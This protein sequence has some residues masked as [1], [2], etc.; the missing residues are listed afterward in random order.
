MTEQATMAHIEPSEMTKTSQQIDIMIAKKNQAL[1]CM[2]NDNMII[3]DCDQQLAR[4]TNKVREL[5]GQVTFDTK[6][7]RTNSAHPTSTTRSILTKEQ[8]EQSLGPI[9]PLK[10]LPQNSVLGQGVRKVFL[11][12]I[13]S[14][15]YIEKKS[16]VR[17]LVDHG[18]K[19]STASNYYD[20]V[21]K[22]FQNRG[23]EVGSFK[24]LR[25]PKDFKLDT[26]SSEKY[27]VETTKSLPVLQ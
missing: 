27:D 16:A 14:L 24:E 4:L 8:M 9:V 15:P 17:F 13:M 18:Y 1:E 23:W 12:Y 22:Y 6:F 5:N 10:G 3:A 20:A 7:A 21:R 26:E 11:D 25:K 2:R 19:K